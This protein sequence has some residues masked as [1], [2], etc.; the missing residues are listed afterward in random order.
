[1][2]RIS[3]L[4]CFFFVVQTPLWSEAKLMTG[5]EGTKA[6][7]E[8]PT[9][10][11]KDI[12][13]QI[14]LMEKALQGG[15]FQ[16]VLQTAQLILSADPHNLRART[17]SVAARAGM[18]ETDLFTAQKNAL[19][20]ST[21]DNPYLYLY[22][23]QAL[24]AADRFQEAEKYFLKG[25]DQ[26]Q[27]NE[28]LLMALARAYERNK[29]PDKARKYYAQVAD[30]KD[31]K[32]QNFLNASFAICRLDLAQKHYK[33]VLKRT[34]QIIDLFPVLPQ[35]YILQAKAWLAQDQPDKALQ[36]YR[37]LLKNN[38]DILIPYKE[39]ALLSIKQGNKTDQAVEIAQQAVDTF[40]DDPEAHDL[41]GWIYLKN[42]QLD[43][44]G[45]SF[46]KALRLQPDNPVYLYHLGLLLMAQHD[47]DGAR[48]NFHKALQIQKDRTASPR[49]VEELNKKIRELEQK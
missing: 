31:K 14:R 8:Q 24:L 45:D 9:L 19:Q 37:K 23:G 47:A 43:K 5:I 33:Q 20:K 21:P 22:T 46:E 17:A 27:D 4:L 15:Q 35:A 10:A 26:E 41:C 18:G 29:Q 40:P 39:L 32:M 30:K 38:P 7:R 28:E 13:L 11:K 6:T 34:N 12:P 36:T 3:I 25:I 2:T 48:K 44:A 42:K 49:F 16:E 1:M